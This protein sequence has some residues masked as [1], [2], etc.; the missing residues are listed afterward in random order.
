MKPK[1]CL[2]FGASGLIGRHLIRKL[3]KNNFKVTAITRNIHKTGYLLKTQGNPGYIEVIEANLFDENKIRN[4]IKKADICVNLVGIL[5]QENK[6]NSFENIHEKFPNFLSNICKEYNV[7]QFL[8]LSALGIDDAKDSL[9]ALSKC[10]G[11]E[12]IRKNFSEATILRPSVVYSVDDNFTTKFMTMLSF[13]PIF[14]LYY[15]GSTLFRPIHV[16]DIAEIIYQI[17]NQNLNSLILECVGPEE[18]SLKDILNRLLK[19]MGKKRLLVPMP[20]IIAYLSTFF[21]QMFPKPLITLDQLKLLKYNNI[22]SGKFKTNFDLSMPS[23]ANFDNEVNK[24][25]YMWKDGGQFSKSNK[26]G[27]S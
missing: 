16:S 18:I 8:H 12:L 1:N 3:T 7:K 13:L 5:H 27:K 20:L 10:K 26:E 4:L 6:I 25:V 22:P 15:N 21:F 24:Y 11:E 23:Y 2:I 19:L 9:Y 14:P 17:V